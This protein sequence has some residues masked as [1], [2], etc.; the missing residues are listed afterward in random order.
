MT[1][2]EYIKMLQESGI[3]GIDEYVTAAEDA[4]SGITNGAN[5]RIA[6][7]E[8]SNAE[9]AKQLQE[10][11][12]RNYVLMM[13]ATSKVDDAPEQGGEKPEE[14]TEDEADVSSLFAG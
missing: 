14:P 7:L 9:L 1:Y 6:E 2:E 3:E 12:A 5:A 10:T 8:T 13:A 4:Y 11:Q